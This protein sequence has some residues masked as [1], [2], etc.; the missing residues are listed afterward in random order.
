[1]ASW[2]AAVPPGTPPLSFSLS[3]S[4]LDLFRPDRKGRARDQKCDADLRGEIA[5]HGEHEDGGQDDENEVDGEGR[6]GLR[7][8]PPGWA[9]EGRSE[10]P[11]EQSA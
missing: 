4:L 8:V 11:A 2:R 7:V 1:M 9:R 6:V 3:L 5:E 10:A